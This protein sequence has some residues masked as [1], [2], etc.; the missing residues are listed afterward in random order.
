MNKFITVTA[1]VLTVLSLT[2]AAQA[3]GRVDG[4]P[5]PHI[6]SGAANPNN[7]RFSRG[8]Y[9]LKVHVAGKPLSQLQI[10]AP[11][12]FR[13]SKQIQVTDRT[14]KPLDAEISLNDQRVVLAFAQPVSPDTVINIDLKNVQKP[15][16]LLEDG[17][18]WYL[19]VSSKLVGLNGSISLGQARIQTY[20]RD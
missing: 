18:V 6:L 7:S 13:L 15:A 11:T 10:D 9:S 12:G 5:I 16:Y 3:S 20:P 17:S 14:G 1:F 2:P 4:T 19:A 8:D